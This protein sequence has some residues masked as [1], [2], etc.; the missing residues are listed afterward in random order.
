MLSKNEREFFKNPKKF[1]DEHS[2]PY[3]TQMFSNFNLK[4]EGIISDLY[5]IY[6]FM[7]NDENSDIKK[8]VFGDSHFF[9]VLIEF[10]MLL[11]G[12]KGKKDKMQ[13]LEKM[14]TFAE[15]Y[16]KKKEKGNNNVKKVDKI[17]KDKKDN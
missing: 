6:T 2:Q 5:H 14:K 8:R 9:K 11:R 16:E 1:M 7:I 13:F 17:D 12:M 15:D 4:L 3:I 10:G